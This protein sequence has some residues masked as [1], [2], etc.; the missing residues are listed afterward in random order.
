MKSE[1]DTTTPDKKSFLPELQKSG[2][3]L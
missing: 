1:F 3:E 2:D